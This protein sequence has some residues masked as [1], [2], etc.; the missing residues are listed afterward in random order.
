MRAL[1]LSTLLVTLTVSVAAAAEPE[2]YQINGGGQK[3]FLSEDMQ[4]FKAKYGARFN[5]DKVATPNDRPMI[6]VLT[7]PLTESQKK[8][9]RFAGKTSYIM[10]SYIN[11]LESAG[12]RTVPL[13]FDADLEG[14]LAKLDHLNGVL[15]CGGGAEGAYVDFGKAIFDKAKKMNDNG[16]Y[17]PVWGTCLGF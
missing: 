15:Y 7:Q 14:E 10:A 8:D 1:L 6:G 9:P 4:G 11:H 13:I 17:F 5:F 16:Q 2:L 12:A 3:K